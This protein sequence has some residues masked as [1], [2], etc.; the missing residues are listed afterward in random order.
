MRKKILY[1]VLI[2]SLMFVFIMLPIPSSDLCIRVHFSKIE[3]ITQDRYCVLYYAT[4]IT[5]EFTEAQNIIQTINRGTKQVEFTLPSSLE[6]HITGLR[7]DFPNEEQLLCISNIT[8][9]SAG[10]VKRQFN[11][12]RF[13]SESN[14]LY[15]NGITEVSL[16]TAQARTYILTS[17]DDPYMILSPSLCRQ[18]TDCYSHFRLTR[19]GICFF[20]LGCCFF[21]KKKIF[22]ESLF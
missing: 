16:A 21:A 8:V 18:I 10:T 17:P 7:L 11:P 5:N 22:N 13:F 6:N 4:D 15:S 3:D 20:I 14:I 9:S 12:C 19:L 1:A 2:L